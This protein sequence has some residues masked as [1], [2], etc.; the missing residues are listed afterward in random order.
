M[1]RLG[2]Y[3][4]LRA[5]LYRVDEYASRSEIYLQGNGIERVFLVHQTVGD[6]FVRG[7]IL[8]RPENP[9][10]H[11]QNASVILVQAI[12]IAS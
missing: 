3:E 6:G 2:R 11:D 7:K 12:Q 10:P 8:E 5:M 9:V 1:I 4:T